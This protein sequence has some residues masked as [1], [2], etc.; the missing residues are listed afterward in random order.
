M[1]DKEVFSLQSYF[2][3]RTKITHMFSTIIKVINRNK[4]ALQMYVIV[5]S[6]LAMRQVLFLDVHKK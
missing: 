4:K 1:A 6:I 2:D 5:T 3:F